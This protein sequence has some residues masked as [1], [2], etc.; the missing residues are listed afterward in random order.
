VCVD[1]DD[2]DERCNDDNTSMPSLVNDD[3]DDNCG[4]DDETS[5]PIAAAVQHHGDLPHEHRPT[6]L[7]VK[8]FSPHTPPL[9]SSSSS[10]SSSLPASAVLHQQSSSL[11]PLVPGHKVTVNDI[12]GR[13]DDALHKLCL[14][15]AEVVDDGC[16]FCVSCL[17]SKS[18]QVLASV[19]SLFPT[20]DITVPTGDNEHGADDDNVDDNLRRHAACAMPCVDEPT[21]H[22]KKSD[23]GVCPLLFSLVARLLPRDEVLAR[24]DARVAADVEIA[25]MQERHVFDTK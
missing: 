13:I 8:S 25:T 17:S 10:L 7:P 22:R 6:P 16:Q 9:P 24:E 1:Y 12:N 14:A 21:T 20:N 19:S 4:N 3:E 5:K 23:E 2:Y 11:V 15:C 18:S